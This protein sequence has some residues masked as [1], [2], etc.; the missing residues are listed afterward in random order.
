MRA[1][2]AQCGTSFDVADGE[3]G[4][5]REPCPRCGS[6]SREAFGAARVDL[7]LSL[8]AEATVEHVVN[9]IRL[10]LFSV[11]LAIGITV[12]FGAPGPWNVGVA[13][14]VAS[15]VVVAAVF[16]WHPAKRR[17]MKLMSWL[18]GGR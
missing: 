6:T 11:L 7:G 9:E 16:R 18:L 3:G 15:V 5:E 10:A 13:S 8:S 4:D 2:C 14:G 12:G 17:L 1:V